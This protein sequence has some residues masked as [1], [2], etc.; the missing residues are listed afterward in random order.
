[1]RNLQTRKQRIAR[2]IVLVLPIMF[3]LF[4]GLIWAVYSLWN[5]L[6]PTIFGLH[7]ITYWQ[8]LGLMALCWI[9]FGGFRGARRSGGSWRHGIRERWGRMTP[10]EREEF[11]KGLNSRCA[12]TQSSEPEPPMK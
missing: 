12:K 7:T 8:A 10:V 3:I 1:M 2:L 5:G 11:I 9:L 6:M 4:A